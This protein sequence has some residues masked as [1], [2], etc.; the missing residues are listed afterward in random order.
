[1]V[2]SAGDQESNEAIVKK[3]QVRSGVFLRFSDFIEAK[4]KVLTL[5]TTSAIIT[6]APVL[7]VATRPAG[8][9]SG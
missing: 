6:F 3:K 2:A 9:Y 4:C 1:M 8:E 5:P 7:K